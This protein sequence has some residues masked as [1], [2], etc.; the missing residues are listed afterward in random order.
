MSHLSL[1]LV[2]GIIFVALVIVPAGAVLQETTFKGT[3]S[4]V[5]TTTQ[6]LTIG[7]PLQYGCVYPVVGSEPACSWT[8]TNFSSWTGTVPDAVALKIFNS[9]DT[10]VGTSIGATGNVWIAL[11]KLYGPLPN[12]E[13][14]TDVI[15]QATS[16]PTPLVGDYSLDLKTI[17]DCTACSGATCV[18]Q[19]ADVV[20]LTKGMV[21]I[22][23]VLSPGDTVTFNGRNDGSSISVTFV[24]GQASSN[25]CSA[26]Q[27]GLVGGVQP[28]SDYIVN[29][30]P[31]VG[32]GQINL[33]TASTT[34]PEEALPTT[35]QTTA[36]PLTT[37][38]PSALPTTAK[39]GL[40]PLTAFA[41]LSLIA[42]FVLAGKR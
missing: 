21:N 35:L 15:G 5:M 13:Y 36:A 9:G 34:R 39:S 10:A 24:K 32:Y 26:A 1:A 6:T 3:V 29:V 40:Q 33:R 20:I 18:A 38:I 4:T 23:K 22:H 30:V 12:Q 31:P 19:S 2:L 11:A 17:P 8:P 7:Y 41:A 42:A 14:A 37:T 27:A 28:I 16:I 25:T